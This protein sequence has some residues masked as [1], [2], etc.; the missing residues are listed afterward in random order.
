MAVADDGRADRKVGPIRI[1]ARVGQ[2]ARGAVDDTGRPRDQGFQPGD[3][4]PRQRLRGWRAEM[5]H[6]HIARLHQH[7]IERLAHGIDGLPHG[8][9]GGIVGCHQVLAILEVRGCE[10]LPIGLRPPGFQIVQAFRHRRRHLQHHHGLGEM[11]EI[12]GGQP[13]EPVDFGDAGAK[14]CGG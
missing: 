6:H 9:I 3:R 4:A 1:G 7:G 5:S 14:W 10:M 12:V 2:G 13:G 11:V 8:R